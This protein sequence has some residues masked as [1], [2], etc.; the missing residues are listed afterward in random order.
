MTPRAHEK[1]LQKASER[2]SFRSISKQRLYFS[3][4][5]WLAIKGLY[6]LRA[7]KT[8]ENTA[9]TCA[10]GSGENQARY[11]QRQSMLFLG[12][13]PKSEIIFSVPF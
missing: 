8:D 11:K 3:W 12:I 4:L 6:T 2:H 10:G 9:D 5:K 13:V 1:K 7:Y